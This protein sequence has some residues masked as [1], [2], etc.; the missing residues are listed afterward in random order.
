MTDSE[1]L[2]ARLI[3]VGLARVAAAL[4]E[5]A[6]PCITIHTVP[7]SDDA[8]P[9]GASKFGGHP[10]LP[11]HFDWPHWNDIP[12]AFLGQINL[13][14]IAKSP[15]AACLPDA[16]LLSFFYDAEQSTWGFDPK[17]RGSWS[18]QLFSDDELERTPPPEGI[19]DYARYSACDLSFSDGLTLPG[20]ETAIIQ[21]LQLTDEEQD[22]LF[23]VSESEDAEEHHLLGHPQEV[24]GEMQLECQLAS[25]GIHCGHPVGYND[26]RVSALKPG[27]ADWVL[28]LQIDSDDNSGWMWGDCG[29]LYFWITK[30]D[31]SESRFDRVWMILQCT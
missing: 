2:R 14:T 8:I 24:Q 27:A 26:A 18:V 17:D 20:S 30:S 21:S 7:N 29:R 3:D 23:D 10:D 11:A 25:N 13:A 4:T 15:V 22:S 12:L 16:G 9:T 31:L 1:G 28:L 19:P 6:A 5:S